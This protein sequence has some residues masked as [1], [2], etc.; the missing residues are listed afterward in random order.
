MNPAKTV[1]DKKTL[2]MFGKGFGG[3]MVLTLRE[4][5]N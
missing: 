5:S 4:T 1:E 3:G 2:G